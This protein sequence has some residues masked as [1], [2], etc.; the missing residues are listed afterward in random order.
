MKLCDKMLYNINNCVRTQ[1]FNSY[2]GNVA[3]RTFSK[4]SQ[5]ETN[6]FLLF[7]RLWQEGVLMWLIRLVDAVFC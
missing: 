5:N 4:V 2:K 7:A 1:N 3:L 6:Q